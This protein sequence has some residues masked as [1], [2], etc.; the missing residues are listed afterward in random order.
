MTITPAWASS[1]SAADGDVAGIGAKGADWL[2]SFAG[3]LIRDLSLAQVEFA[4]DAAPGFI[5]QFAIPEEIIDTLAL[6]TDEEKFD[7]VMQ[8]GQ[9]PMAC[10]HEFKFLKLFHLLGEVWF[11]EIIWKFALKRKFAK[12]IG[13]CR[14][15]LQACLILF[16]AFGTPLDAPEMSYTEGSNHGG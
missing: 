11:D 5:L 2:T 8:L 9:P 13:R 10:T 12:A 3:L 4:L 1:E 16:G 7:L 6:G 15:R 14:D